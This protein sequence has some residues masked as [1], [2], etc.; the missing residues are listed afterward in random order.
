MLQDAVGATGRLAGYFATL[1]ETNPCQDLDDL[2]NDPEYRWDL[3]HVIL[4]G[5]DAE[6][7]DHWPYDEADELFAIE[8]LSVAWRRVQN[9]NLTAGYPQ[10]LALLEEF[11]RLQVENLVLGRSHW[12]GRVPLQDNAVGPH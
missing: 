10:L 11:G 6:S 8:T 9:R 5:M 2:V 7:L 12:H 4:G 1:L 3:R